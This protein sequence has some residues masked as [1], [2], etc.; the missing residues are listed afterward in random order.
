MSRSLLSALLLICLACLSS[1]FTSPSPPQAMS[2]VTAPPPPKTADPETETK[3]GARRR[4]AEDIDDVTVYREG[5]LEYLEDEWE[6]RDPED[7]FHILLLG[8]TFEKKRVTQTYVS[9]SISYVL[10]MP[11]DEA[12]ELT[13]AAAE[14]GLSC[15]GTWE[16]EE[17]LKL[18]R[19]LQ[20]RDIVCRVVPFAEGGQR[21]WQ[22][23]D[24]NDGVGASAGAGWGG[25]GE[26]HL[27][28]IPGWGS[29]ER[30]VI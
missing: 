30:V 27:T 23:K 5:P 29:S 24:A 12:V 25:D 14:N 21:G 2:T 18:G 1:A 22:A 28:E 7:P 11:E 19:Q 13:V 9:G 6:T 10:G 15:L 16:R 17:C 3:R 26:E 20:V 8:A 4:S